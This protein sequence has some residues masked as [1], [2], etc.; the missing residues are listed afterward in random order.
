MNERETFTQRA[1]ILS[2]IVLVIL[3]L[4]LQLWGQSER[5][6]TIGTVT[7]PQGA[8]VSG[9][10]VTVTNIATG[11][12]T[13]AVTDQQGQYQV[14][15]L[16]IGSYKVKVEHEGFKTTE[17][18]SYTLEINQILRVDVRLPIGAIN[19]LV[20]V[21]GT[22]ATVETVNH[23]MGSTVSGREIE[24]APLNGR[25]ALDLALLQ[26][27][28]LP[29]DNPGNSTTNNSAS[30]AFSIGGGRNDS[31]TFILDGGLNNNLLDNSV[32]YNP[33]PD[34][35]QEFRVLTSNFSAEYGRNAGG[36]V[37]VV[38]KSGTNDWHG[39]A[40]EYN[41]NTDYDANSYNLNQ[42]G[43][44][45][46]IL[47]RNQYGGTV[48]GPVIK[49]KLFFFIAYQGQRQSQ[50]IPS[51]VGTTFTPAEL[52]GNF[53][54]LGANT[55]SAGLCASQQP[56]Q[57]IGNLPA[58][59]PNPVATFLQANPFFQPNPA[60]AAQ[61]IISPAAFDPVAQAYIKAGLIP[62][63]QTGNITFQD[64]SQ[65]NYN[66][67]TGKFDWDATSKDRFTVTLG[68]NKNPV[69][70][71]NQFGGG[72]NA[73]GNNQFLSQP[74][75]PEF[76][77]SG[78]SLLE[79]FNLAYIRTISS[80]M[81]NEFRVTAQRFNN[82]QGIPGRTFGSASSFGTNI[83][84]T[85]GPSNPPLLTF[86]GLSV[87][88]SPQ[89]PTSLENN[90]FTYSDTLSWTQG[91]NNW[92]FGGSFVA[93]RNN[94]VF[95]F[96]VNGNFDY[97]NSVNGATLFG[98]G[99]AFGNFL[100]GIPDFY[101]QSPAAPSTIR[102]KAT[103]VFGQDEW[104]AANN[105]VLTLGL[106]YEYSTPKSDTQG[107]TFSVIPGEQST[108]YPGAPTGLVFPGD[109]GAPRGSNFPDKT[110][111]APRF[112]FAWQPFHDGKTSI[113][114]GFGVFYDILKA[115]DNFQFNGQFPFAP[116]AFLGF[117]DPSLTP[118]PFGLVTQPFTSTGNPN[119]FANLP[120]S[121][122]VNFAATVGTF[123][124]AGVFVVDP[125]L[126][127]PYTYQYNLTIE[128]EVARK[129]TFEMAYVGSSSHG[130]TG[131]KDINPFDLSTL[132]NPIPQRILNERP[133]DLPATANFGGSFGSMPEFMNVVNANYNALQLSL[134]QQEAAVPVLGH[135]YYTLGYTWAHSIDDASGFRNDIAHVPFYQP[136]LFYASSDFDLRQAM[137]FSGGWDLPF[138]AGPKLLVKGWS[139]YPIL[140]WRTGFPFT[141]TDGLTPSGPGPS[142]AGD[143]NLV[144][145][146][147][148]APIQYIDSHATGL[149]FNPNS[150]SAAVNSGYG[151]APRN[152]FTG[153]GRTNLDLSLAKLTPLYGERVQLR[154]ALDAF[155]VFNH[156][157]FQALGTNA[158]N[159]GTLGQ[160]TQ[161]Y[162]PRIL[163]LSARIAF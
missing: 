135:M 140:S 144:S 27:G 161:T 152:G 97:T 19:E 110:N 84:T 59:C 138:N 22:A 49:N 29:A 10:N 151:T 94:L 116:T 66:E 28:V 20:T 124:G 44:P 101:F 21:E 145:A 119:P 45:R 139:L 33:N 87:G 17:T 4:S 153:P 54:S 71:P 157:E 41:R 117:N 56:N 16:P 74:A 112:G 96:F 51:A 65:N 32:V 55:A 141:V 57:Q 12:A 40:F 63:T 149:F 58:G 137:T 53:S 91:R 70:G 61:G 34:A 103:Y 15:E 36:I 81:L 3:A 5:A 8:V 93:Y 9:A 90:T 125:H 92:K 85:E 106:R 43:A 129:M 89:G 79:F 107:R 35:I 86:P 72:A 7:D 120:I 158:Q 99:N 100:I 50:T 13:K 123:G 111:F 23:T 48:G 42:V 131:L 39:T 118:A 25:N 46:A 88:F 95:D 67:L 64:P 18:T 162:A 82:T 155:N 142:G 109:A 105:L 14:P 60:L 154:L 136:H 11:V 73:P 24:N 133:G 128:H 47:Q 122:N 121:H 113:R 38:T 76:T 114:G 6:R 1:A 102:T 108:V 126:R 115:E 163:Q 83:D 62:T 2:R 156:T 26:P 80:H 37:S 160:V 98:A 130:L 134:R 30:T 78:A 132:N 31:N 147:L 146:N 77:S 148:V 150:F 69:S 104:H 68:R 143:G 52:Q 127:T 159:P 75:S